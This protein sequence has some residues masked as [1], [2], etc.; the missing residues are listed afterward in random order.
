MV[1]DSSFQQINQIIQTKVNDQ[2]KF[3]MGKCELVSWHQP[4]LTIKILGGCS[5]CPSSALALYNQVSEIL[6]SELPYIEEIE[7]KQ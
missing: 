7:L 2:L 6:R 5:G 1:D 3:H 4:V